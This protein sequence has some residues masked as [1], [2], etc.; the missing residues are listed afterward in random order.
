MT[1][2]I[3]AKV[4]IHVWSYDFY[5]MTLSTEKQQHHVIN[6][7][8]RV[9]STS[10]SSAVINANI[11]THIILHLIFDKRGNKNADPV[12][13]SGYTVNKISKPNMWVLTF[14]RLKAV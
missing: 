4:L 2:R 6:C 5:D 7:F 11:V 3:C 10:G 1:L 12:T 9:N 14:M 13:F 8:M